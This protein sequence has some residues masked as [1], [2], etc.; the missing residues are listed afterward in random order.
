MSDKYVTIFIFKTQMKGFDVNLLTWYGPSDKV[1]AYVNQLDYASDYM[2][3]VL[4]VAGDWSNYQH[5]AVDKNWSKY[6]TNKGLMKGQ[7]LNFA[8]DRNVN[9]LKYY[10]GLSLIP[11]FRDTNGRNIF[12]ETN[13]NQDTNLTGVFCAFDSDKLE[14][15]FNTGLIDLIG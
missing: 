9:T 13:I 5:L 6:F 10:Q 14:K 15:E 11:Y 7:V 1:P 12:I 8:N 3:D 4:I 2:V